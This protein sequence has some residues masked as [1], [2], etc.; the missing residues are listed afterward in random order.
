MKILFNTDKNSSLREDIKISSISLLLDKLKRFSNQVTRL[1]VFLS[2]ENGKK[3]GHND[4][5]CI[6]EARLEGRQPVAVTNQ[7]CTHEEALKGA[8]HK[9]VSSLNTTCERL[10]NY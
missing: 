10:R 5:Q 8:I 9:L 3:N 1:D 7:A 6:L 4:K 2:D